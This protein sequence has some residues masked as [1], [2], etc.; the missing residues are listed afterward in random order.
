LSIDDLLMLIIRY[1]PFWV[2]CRWSTFHY[3]NMISVFVALVDFED[4]Q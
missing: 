2:L 4:I 1:W 3:L